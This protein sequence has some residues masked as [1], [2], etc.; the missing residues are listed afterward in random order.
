MIVILFM[1]ILQ[2]VIVDFCDV[3]VFVFW[4]F[5]LGVFL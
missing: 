3:L 4:L 5:D 2:F 1:V